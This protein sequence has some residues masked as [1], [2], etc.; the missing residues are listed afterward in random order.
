MEGCEE[1]LVEV[2]GGTE[3]E[4]RGGSFESSTVMVRA[5]VSYEQCLHCSKR[6]AEVPKLKD[7]AS[8]HVC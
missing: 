5:R 8:F 4:S 3:G 1:S 6:Q 2:R 7:I